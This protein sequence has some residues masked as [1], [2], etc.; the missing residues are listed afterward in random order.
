MFTNDTNFRRV[1]GSNK[2]ISNLPINLRVYSPHVLNITLI[3]LPGLTKV[4]VG[5]QPQD[6][7]QQI[8]DMLLQVCALKEKKTLLG[9]SLA[10]MKLRHLVL[11]ITVVKLP[12]ESRFAT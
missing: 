6:I 11:G 3:D 8:R 9:V 4:A 12:R 1:T 10:W 2:G 5:D 7:E